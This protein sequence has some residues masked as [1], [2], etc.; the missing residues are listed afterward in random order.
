MPRPHT[1]TTPPK[2][3]SS[4]KTLVITRRCGSQVSGRLPHT[5]GSS[6]SSKPLAPPLP[7]TG[8]RGVM[9]DDPASGLSESDGENSSEDDEAVAL[10]FFEQ[11]VLH[12]KPSPAPR[13][14]P[15]PPPPPPP[16]L[17]PEPPPDVPEPPALAV[18]DVGGSGGASSS[19]SAAPVAPAMPVRRPANGPRE[20]ESEP[21]GPFSLAPLKRQVDGV[22]VQFG[23]GA[24]CRRHTD[25]TDKPGTV[26]QKQVTDLSGAL[27]LTE[28]KRL[29]KC[30]LL[31]GEGIDNSLSDAR[32]QHV[33]G[34]K[35]AKQGPA[36]WTDAE[37]GRIMLATVW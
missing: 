16:A 26:C 18:S 8:P 30:W 3:T 31:L 24:T 33:K 15:V 6:S 2:P 32:T 23:W 9:P 34:V 7:R 5:G 13:P 17:H 28:C 20:S 21:W 14:S 27:T 29:V 35:P 19:A 10:A 4:A 37:W 12:K 36:S 1:T 25:L 11:L 22:K